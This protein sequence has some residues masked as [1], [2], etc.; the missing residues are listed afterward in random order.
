MS[1][2]TENTDHQEAA[3]PARAFEDLRAEVSVLRRAVEA[4]PAAIAENRPPDYA[5]DLG[6]LGKGLDAI[7]TQLDAIQQYRFLNMTPQQHGQSI[8]QAGSDMLREATQKLDYAANIADRERDNL[9]TMIG[10]ARRKDEQRMW[11]IRTGGAGLVLGLVMFPLL[12][13]V[14]PFGLNS[15]MAA[16]VMGANRWD[17]G[18]ALMQAGNPAGWTQLTADANLA[19]ANRDK[20]ATCRA[21]AAKTKQEERCTISVPPG[22]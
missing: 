17:A 3:D 7:G 19:A 1:E 2:N 5:A 4:L 14:L 10:T 13:R 8:A 18:V 20:I 6:V 9:K 12:M 15:Y 21:A 22:G 11:L 16:A